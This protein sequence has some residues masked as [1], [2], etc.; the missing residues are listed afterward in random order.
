VKSASG[1][2][3]IGSLTLVAHELRL[4]DAETITQQ[5]RRE[6]LVLDGVLPDGRLLELRPPDGGFATLL[7]R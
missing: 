1:E 2:K 3:H 5:E 6:V 4:D 7:R